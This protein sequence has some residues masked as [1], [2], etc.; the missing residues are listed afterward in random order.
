MDVYV[1]FTVQLG[2]IAILFILLV[3]VLVIV[4]DLAYDLA[5]RDGRGE[6]EVDPDGG[7]SRG[8]RRAAREYPSRATRYDS[9]AAA[10]M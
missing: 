2:C 5:G 3:F 4:M 7:A 6:P 8:R 10:G 1:Y 9:P